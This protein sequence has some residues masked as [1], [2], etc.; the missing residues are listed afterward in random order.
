MDKTLSFQVGREISWVGSCG[1]SRFKSE[2]L[3]IIKELS[4]A[5]YKRIRHGYADGVGT[6]NKVAIGCSS[7]S[8]N[9]TK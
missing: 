7:S 5:D 4:Q 2:K 3:K 9:S 1:E 8:I 6:G